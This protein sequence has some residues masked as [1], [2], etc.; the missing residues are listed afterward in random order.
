VE[1]IKEYEYIY[2]IKNKAF[3]KNNNEIC[4]NDTVF[5]GSKNVLVTAGV[6]EVLQPFFMSG[7]FSIKYNFLTIIK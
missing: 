5:N 4:L 3:D 1:K 6:L 2:D 7:K